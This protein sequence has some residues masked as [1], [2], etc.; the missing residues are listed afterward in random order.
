MGGAE[1][2]RT[3]QGAKRTLGSWLC[4]GSL[5]LRAYGH[6]GLGREDRAA[7]AFTLIE[8]LVVV[9]IIGALAGISVPVLVRARA[10]AG[11]VSCASNLG[12]LYRA[13][14]MYAADADGLLPPYT[15]SYVRIEQGGHPMRRVDR[16]EC[17]RAALSPYVKGRGVWFC[18]ADIF[19]GRAHDTCG[20]R[21][22][23]CVNHAVTSYFT[24]EWWYGPFPAWQRLLHPELGR[25]PLDITWWSET[26]GRERESSTTEMLTDCQ[27]YSRPCDPDPAALLYRLPYSHVGGSNFVYFD[28]HV[29]FGWP[30]CWN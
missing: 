21:G 9:V 27:D 26:Y 5:P 12:Q 2:D 4:P 29:R 3:R 30:E 23:Y 20:T 8:L 15:T 28:G 17:L 24:S 6:A 25:T 10:R 14:A 19:A 13:I 11:T 18:A 16:S 22:D 1:V 7:T